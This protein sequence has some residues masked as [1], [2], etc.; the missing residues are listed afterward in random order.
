[1]IYVDMFVYISITMDFSLD[2]D[3]NM[4]EEMVINM[5]L[6]MLTWL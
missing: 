1:M 6:N 2:I 5:E 3:V 4:G